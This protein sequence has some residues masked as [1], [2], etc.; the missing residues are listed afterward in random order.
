LLILY[1]DQYIIN[2][3]ISW[4]RIDEILICVKSEDLVSKAKHRLQ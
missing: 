4:N 1:N 2:L 3:N